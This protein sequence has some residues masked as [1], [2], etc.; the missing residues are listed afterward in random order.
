MKL[1]DCDREG[2]KYNKFIAGQ[3]AEMVGIAI[4]VVTRPL[5]DLF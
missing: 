5:E 4:Y 1:L 3:G 2:L